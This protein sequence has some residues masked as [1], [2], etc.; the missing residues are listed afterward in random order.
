MP[1]SKL[2][3][4]DKA[5]IRSHR[6]DPITD[7]VKALDRPEK[8]VQSF[9]D[10]IVSQNVAMIPEVFREG[11]GM[12]SQ[13]P[14]LANEP[15][16]LQKAGFAHSDAADEKRRGIVVSTK[17]A[18]ERGDEA[19]AQKKRATAELIR[20]NPAIFIPNNNKPAY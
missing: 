15:T 9:V 19:R 13:N 5:Y 17:A 18:S 20:N 16:A 8:L 12:K 2:S 14:E 1:P 3:E 4:S 11:R 6:E 7:L 10:E